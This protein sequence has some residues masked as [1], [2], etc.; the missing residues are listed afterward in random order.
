MEKYLKF[1]FIM[2]IIQFVVILAL[3]QQVIA[4]QNNLQNPADESKTQPT[5]QVKGEKKSQE[6]NFNFVEEDWEKKMNVSIKEFLQ[7]KYKRPVEKV[8]TTVHINWAGVQDISNAQADIQNHM[9]MNVLVT[10]DKTQFSTDEL[11]EMEYMIQQLKE[12]QSVAV[13]L[14]PIKQK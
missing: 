9:K 1:S 3:L 6:M 14:E 7:Y 5:T 13:T 8:L 12:F 10:L 4:T 2:G 11:L